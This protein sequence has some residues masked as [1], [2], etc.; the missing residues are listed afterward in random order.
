M[1]DFLTKAFEQ[2]EAA[3]MPEA[4]S[5]PEAAPAQHVTNVFDTVNNQVLEIPENDLEA[6]L[7]SGRYTLPKGSEVYMKAPGGE[8]GTIPS[9]NVYQAIKDGFTLE[10]SAERNQRELE[11]KYGDRSGEA[12]FQGAARGL[13][14]GLSD[15]AQTATGFRTPEEL[16]GLEQVN[17]TASTIGEV[18]GIV[19]G[20]VL[21][22][23]AL[24]AGVKGASKVAQVTERALAKQ[25]AKAGVSNKIAQGIVQKIVPAAAG[26]AVEGTLYG[27]GQLISENAL[28]RAD[29]N[30]ENLVGYLGT[31]ALVGGVAGGALK[32][33]GMLL[34]PVATKVGKKLSSLGKKAEETFLNKERA[35]TELAGYSP[36]QAA[37]LG[38][39]NPTLVKELP[40]FFKQNLNLKPTDSLDDLVL[41]TEQSLQRSSST[42]DDILTKV[43]GSGIKSDPTVFRN[44]A[45]EIR[46]TVIGPYRSTPGFEAAV[47]KAEKFANSLDALSAKG[48]SLGVKQLNQMRKQFDELVN[49]GKGINELPMFQE[50]AYTARTALRSEIDNLANKIDPQLGAELKAANRAYHIGTEVLPHMKSKAEKSGFMD[51][52]DAVLSTGAVLGG[53]PGIVLGAAAKF[54]QSDLRRK[55]VILSNIERAQQQVAQKMNKALSGFFEQS[56]KKVRQAAPSTLLKSELSSDL[57][58]PKPKS[59]KNREIAFRNIVQNLNQYASNPEQ[60]IERVNKTSSLLYDAA[61]ETS[62]ALDMVVQNSVAFLNS[63]LPRQ[64]TQKGVLAAMQPPKMPADYEVAKFER[65]LKAVENPLSVVEDLKNGDLTSEGAEALRTVYPALYDGLRQQV[66]NDL[67]SKGLEVPY[68]KRLQLGLLL[69][70][71]SDE[72]LLPENVIAL[73][74]NFA[75]PPPEESKSAVNPT[76]SGLGSLGKN[77]SLET[78][79]ERDTELT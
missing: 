59:P 32:G 61:P 19:G 41:K 29:F 30:A 3:P 76:V 1:A 15:V 43:E 73:Q 4:V 42:I 28:G 8:V 37:K 25:L 22:V 60:L 72:S 10:S 49:Y 9:S 64:A 77:T 54:A 62:G 47:R 45:Q 7:A 55:L 5:A 38:N 50:A 66:M 31:G 27:T 26:S 20:L 12:L 78:D 69:N 35:S 21:P 24:G 63:K 51:L 36:S 70:I 57:S 39:R 14:F 33:T 46:D 56:G 44:A 65:Y 17:P 34:E 71:A 11:A 18:G 58:G 75:T 79:L 67:A 68:Q 16:S 23:G 53:A 52:K 40:D 74:Q 13:S 48:D 6:A 2:P